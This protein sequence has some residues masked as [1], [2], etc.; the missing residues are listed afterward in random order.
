MGIDITNQCIIVSALMH[1]IGKFAQRAEQKSSRQ[2]ESAYC[3]VY[4]G[5]TTHKH[6]L[7]TDFF[8]ESADFPLPHELQEHRSRIARLAAVHHNPGVSNENS[9]KLLE[10]IIQKADCF[11]SGL[12][13]LSS[14]EENNYKKTRLESIFSF[15]ELRKPNTQK[16]YHVLQKQGEAK[17]LFPCSEKEN[18]TGDY[19]K[20]LRILSIP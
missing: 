20:L 5:K 2:L 12:D 11:S 4:N 18:K 9:E 19:E 13:R 16:K 6:V 1:D 15:I 3:P 10:E 8:I 14:E 7:Y 17:A